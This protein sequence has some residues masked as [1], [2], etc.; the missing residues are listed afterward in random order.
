M[1]CRKSSSGFRF[2]AAFGTCS[3]ESFLFRIMFTFR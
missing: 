3:I 1:L 2:R